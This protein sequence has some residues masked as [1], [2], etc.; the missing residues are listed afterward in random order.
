M[1]GELLAFGRAA[2][3]AYYDEW[4]GWKSE[5]ERVV[6]ATSHLQMNG[7]RLVE[8]ECTQAEIGILLLML[9]LEFDWLETLHERIKSK[10]EIRHTWTLNLYVL[11]LYVCCVT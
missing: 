11:G 8:W 6:K 3:T 2:Y 7:K 10:K 4:L 9:I 1:G 5:F